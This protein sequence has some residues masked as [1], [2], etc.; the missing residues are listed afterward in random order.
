[1]VSVSCSSFMFDPRTQRVFFYLFSTPCVF[2][3]KRMRQNGRR[4]RDI[5]RL[6]AP[7]TRQRQDDFTGIQSCSTQSH[8]FIT[9]DG[10]TRPWIRLQVLKRNAA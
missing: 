6:H 7:F 8:L 1:M 9:Q 5:Q 2:G 4:S 3:L 10:Q